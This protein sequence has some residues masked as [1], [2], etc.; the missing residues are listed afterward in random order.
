MMCIPY[1]TKDETGGVRGMHGA[2]KKHIPS[3]GRET[4][5]KKKKDTA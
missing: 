1:Q 3:F 5:G 4:W 2:H